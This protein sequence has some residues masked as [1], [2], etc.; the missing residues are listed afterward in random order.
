MRM[1]VNLRFRCLV[2]LSCTSWFETTVIH[3][4]YRFFYM[5][6]FSFVDCEVTGEIGKLHFGKKRKETIVNNSK[7]RST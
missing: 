6:M 1:S 2:C 7:K 3:I 4:I 5:T